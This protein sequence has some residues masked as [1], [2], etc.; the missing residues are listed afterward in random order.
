M[1]DNKHSFELCEDL[2]TGVKELLKMNSCVSV[3]FQGKSKK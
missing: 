1:R 2:T 3:V